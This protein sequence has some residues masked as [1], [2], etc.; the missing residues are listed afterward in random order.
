M[1]KKHRG[2]LK[3]LRCEEKM[4]RQAEKGQGKEQGGRERIEGDGGC[5]EGGMRTMVELI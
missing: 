3:S 1:V 5:K 4:G 2:E